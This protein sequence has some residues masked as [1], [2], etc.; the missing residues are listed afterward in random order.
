M[1]LVC[2]TQVHG[3]GVLDY[4]TAWYIKAVAYIKGTNIRCAFV[5]T[6]SIT[7]GEQVGVLWSWILG[8]GVKIH[9][10]HR[11]F[12]WTSEARGKANVF[13]VIIGFSLVEPP[14]WRAL[15][16]YD[17]PDGKPR[18]VDAWNINPY[19]VNS[20][21]V[22]VRSRTTPLNGGDVD[23]PEIRFG[24]MPND[25]GNLILS[26]EERKEL[27]LSEPASKPFI[28]RLV[29]SQEFLNG[30][31][32]YCL[33]LKD[34]K[35]SELRKMKHVIE[36]VEATRK[37]REASAR[38][39]TRELA[40]SPGTFGEDRQPT[41]RYLLIPATSSERRK[42]VPIAFMSPDV[43]ASNACLTVS[44]AKLYHFGVLSS[45]AHM[46]WL[47]AVGGRLKGDYRYANNIVY[48]TFPWPH[49]TTIA[50][51]KSVEV[52]AKKLIEVRKQFSSSTLADLYD[53]DTMPRDLLLAHRT[54]D[55]A[56]DRC[57]RNKGF[58]NDLE[59]LDWLF[60]LYKV[61]MEEMS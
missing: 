33:W 14:K 28:K 60:S 27:L 15:Y 43:I 10:A 31:D 3:Y 35:P 30:E 55:R 42:Y 58:R 11:T 6:N 5:S 18:K 47:K 61:K 39:T 20:Y 45:V 23:V 1:E 52:A 50:K 13:C 29:G 24:S 8:K 2:T 4:V 34:A 59:R 56:V 32:R 17:K 16:E 41:S 40:E 51:I 21:D 7:Q 25:G 48:N 26:T 44:G 46:Q 38:E 22:V 36:R 53:P 19:L 57:Y 49:H 12:R 37:H 9:F 54:L